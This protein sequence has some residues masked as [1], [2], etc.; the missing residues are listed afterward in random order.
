MCNRPYNAAIRCNHYTFLMY[1]SNFN[2]PVILN[3][4]PSI[5]NNKI[6]NY[7]HCDKTTSNIEK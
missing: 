4:S 7:N 1:F 6:D 3:N 5:S 2:M